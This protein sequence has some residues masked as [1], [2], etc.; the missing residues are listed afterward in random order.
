MGDYAV[1][2]L[3]L[4]LNV[5][6]SLGGTFQSTA[7]MDFFKGNGSPCSACVN[8]SNLDKELLDKLTTDKIQSIE[9]ISFLPKDKNPVGQ[10]TFLVAN[11]CSN[12]MAACFLNHALKLSD[13][14]TRTIFYLSDFQSVT[15]PM[16]AKEGCA[17]CS[18]KN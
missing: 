7:T 8:D 9:D 2:S 18:H 15:W 4:S 11:Q 16:E 1:Q 3:A 6:L 14:P 17:L 12:L 5:P 13:P 10:S